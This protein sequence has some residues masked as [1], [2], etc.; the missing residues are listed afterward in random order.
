M[1]RRCSGWADE[2]LLATSERV[3]SDENERKFETEN[4]TITRF[5]CEQITLYRTDTCVWRTNK[6][7]SVKIS[8]L[9]N[10]TKARLAARRAG[11][12]AKALVDEVYP[13][14]GCPVLAWVWLGR[15]SCRLD[16]ANPQQ[17]S[18]TL[19][20]PAGPLRLDFYHA[21]HPRHVMPVA[22]SSSRSDRVGIAQHSPSE[23]R[24]FFK[25]LHRCF[26]GMTAIRRQPPDPD[27]Q[28][29][30]DTG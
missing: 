7:P 27:G 19:T 12:P 9:E 10:S 6:L 2:R 23:D 1:G 30:R 21:F 5:T 15:G 8:P 22:P 29:C 14:L 20:L 17:H 4:E 18:H 28:A 13:N 16:D 11:D 25:L 3:S 24:L 26:P